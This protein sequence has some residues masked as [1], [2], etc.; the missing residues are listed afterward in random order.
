MNLLTGKW[1]FV[2]N[3]LMLV[4]LVLLGLYLFDDTLGFAG[5]FGELSVYAGSA[6][7]KGGVPDSPPPLDWVI[8]ML[9]GVFL[10]GVSGALLNGSWKVALA[11]E[12]EKTFGWKLLKTIVF[13][14]LSGFLVMLGSLLAG[15]AFFGQ[16]AAAMEL[17]AGAWLF[18][19]AA[20]ASGGVTALFL[21]RRGSGGAGG[22]SG[23]SEE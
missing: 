19:I 5:A 6:V 13:G 20:L 18:L 16:F 2:V 10:G 1:P 9:G 23:G 7:E 8:G 17:S 21:E 3:A 14:I 15:E 4:L 11:F 22:K 12:E